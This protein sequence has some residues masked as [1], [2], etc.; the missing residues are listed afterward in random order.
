IAG[1]T[2]AWNGS[3]GILDAPDFRFGVSF[4]PNGHQ[5]NHITGN[6]IHSNGGLGIDVLPPPFPSGEPPFTP[7]PNDSCDGDTGGNLRQNFPEITRAERAGAATTIEGFL[8]SAPNASYTVELFASGAADLSGAGE[9]ETFLTALS[10][11]TDSSCLGNFSITLPVAVP[12]GHVITATATDGAGNTSEFSWAE[13]V[14]GGNEP[15][16]ADAGDD[17]T[18]AVDESCQASIFLDGSGSSDPDGDALTYTWTGPFGTA[19]GETATVT[20]T[21]G[22]HTITLTVDDGQGG[23]DSDEVVVTVVDT[24][25]PAIAGL[26]VT[27]GVL[28]PPNH[29]MRPVAVSASAS[30]ACDPAPPACQLV[31][32]ASNEPVDGLGDGDTAPD[33][34]ITGAMTANLRAERSGTGTGRIYT[35]AVSC[36]DA[37][38]NAASGSTGVAVPHSL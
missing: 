17:Q 31:S 10:V 14:V 1:N 15:P 21:P 29:K 23:T 35:L 16:V 30:D 20:L 22:V 32:V 4:T 6:S 7:T 33:W 34:I 38:G 37:A 24:T 19:S 13:E 12:P 9:G 5:G 11:A 18:A 28:W 3:N 26:S 36:R 25:P 27:P 2:I 8:N